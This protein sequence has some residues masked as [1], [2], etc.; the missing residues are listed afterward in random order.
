[1]RGIRVNW[2]SAAVRLT[3]AIHQIPDSPA[4]RHAHLF[5]LIAL[6]ILA[7]GTVAFAQ[8]VVKPLAQVEPVTV[9]ALDEVDIFKALAESKP[10][11]PEAGASKAMLCA[12][13]HGVD[14][15]P[16]DD[17]VYPRIA[18][19]SE[20]FVA[21][22]LALFKTGQRT[23]GMASEMIPFAVELSTQ[24]MRDIGAFFETQTTGA[25]V[26]DD[27]VVADGVYKDLPLYQIGERLF[28]GG[29][30]ARGIPACMA[31]H[32]P[33]GAGNPS[34]AYPHVAGQN[35]E[36]VERRLHN[37]RDGIPEVKNTH[38]FDIMATVAASL[39][40]QEIAAL[41]SYLQGLHPT[42]DAAT[43]AAIAQ[44]AGQQQ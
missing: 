17:A 1:V 11:D 22:Q 14:G 28:R 10:G 6:G 20:R 40:D 26:A 8:T 41:A 23:T 3:V 34:P 35:A 30:V 36:Y 24:D 18:G 2:S 4:M 31:C 21:R 42:P 15:N 25:G 7:A 27:S 13:C 29:D 39:T 43:R 16:V 37:Y 32:G 19:Q 5:T 38:L 9:A 33:S 12:A 44:A